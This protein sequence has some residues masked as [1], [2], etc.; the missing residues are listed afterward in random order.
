MSVAKQSII[1]VLNCLHRSTLGG[2]QQ[3]V[4]EVGEALLE[5]GIQTCVLF[6]KDR[7]ERYEQF[8]RE[9]HFPYVRLR[10]PQI[11]AAGRVL[12]NL[13]FL[14]GFPSQVT[15]VA[16]LI[17]MEKFDVV[18]VNGATNIGPVFAGII[19]N[20]PVI[21]HWN[22]TLT[23]KWFVA[24]VKWLLR[25]PEVRLVAASRA[26]PDTYD[27]ASVGDKFLGILPPPVLFSDSPRSPDHECDSVADIPR[28][29]IVV[30]FVSNLLK[31]KGALEFVEV[32]RRLR[33]EG[34]AVIGIMAGGVLPGHEEY[35]AEVKQ[36]A[37]LENG[38]VHLLGHR[39]DVSALMSQFHAL[40]FPSHTEAAPIVVLQALARGLPV[41]ATPV[42]NVS[43]MLDGLD[44]PVVAVGDIE[45]MV[46]GVRKVIGMSAAERAAYSMK[47]KLRI[48]GEYSLVAVAERHLTVYKTVLRNAGLNG[49]GGGRE[50]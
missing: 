49:V 31:A 32:V 14:L 34:L 18:H 42:G 3:R 21:W 37:A 28:D 35:A 4:V 29:A 9:R 30:G 43:E 2:G 25:I 48:Q 23:P 33:A 11:R 39:N 46:A 38:G 24:C 17:R 1:R 6:P 47:A 19:T 8:L 44:M 36:R 27:I 41:V 50:A 12:S 13:Q 15:R 7:E 40:L 45:A 10:M 16:R 26:I 22:D 5:K 20:R